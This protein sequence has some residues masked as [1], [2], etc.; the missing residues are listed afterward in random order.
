MI[1]SSYSIVLLFDSLLIIITFQY[2]TKEKL[3][4]KIIKF[5]IESEINVIVSENK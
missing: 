2:H 3:R 1:L 5:S 4:N